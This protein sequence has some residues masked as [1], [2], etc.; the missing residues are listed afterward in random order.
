MIGLDDVKQLLA[1]ADEHTLSLY[2][3]VDPALQENQATIPA[4]RIWLKNA[5]KGVEK[6]LTDVQ[7][8]H[9]NNI[10]SRLE[11]FFDTYAPESKG[12]ALFYGPTLEAVHPLPVP[13]ENA[14]AFGKPHIAPLIW[15]IDEYEPYLIVMVDT[16]KAQFIRAYLGSAG[17]QD[18]MTLELDTSDWRE[19]TL[20]PPA[21]RRNVAA[22]GVTHGDQREAFED[23][24]DEWV[25][26]FYRDVATRIAELAQE[27][28]IERFVIAG[29]EES[30]HAVQKLLPEKL[31]KGVVDVQ[32]IPMRYAPHEA[33]RQILPAA[34]E[35]ERRREMELVEQIVNLAKAGGRGA[36][37]KEAV[38][39]AL[40]QQR[41]ELLV[42]PWPLPDGDGAVADLPLRMMEAGGAMELVHGEAADRVKAEGGLAARLYYAL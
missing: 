36:L 16:E 20:M 2:L 11:P 23:R 15:T 4:W 8:P 28:G 22:G 7:R 37:G 41:V 6:D 19:K 35:D 31:V 38:L 5:L 17:Q 1:Q 42:V 29:S 32:G 12:L 30:A 34:L 27:Q 24:V 26:R 33:L 13:V 14:I 9:W 18:T 21:F 39:H 25:G 3:A 10:R 40:E